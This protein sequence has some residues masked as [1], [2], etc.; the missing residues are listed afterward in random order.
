MSVPHARAFWLAIGGRS[1]SLSIGVTHSRVA[2]GV[3]EMPK[4]KLKS[5]S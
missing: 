2:S 1:P 4:S 3:L 5:L